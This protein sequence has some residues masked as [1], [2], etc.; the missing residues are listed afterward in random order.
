[1]LADEGP[2]KDRANLF[3]NILGIIHLLTYR[4]IYASCGQLTSPIVVLMQTQKQYTGISCTILDL[5]SRS[6][7]RFLME[8]RFLLTTSTENLNFRR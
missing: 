3:M 1:M 2:Q 8:V 5:D 6:Y 4:P 7:V